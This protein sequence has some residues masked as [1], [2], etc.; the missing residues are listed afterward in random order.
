MNIASNNTS[1]TTK[2]FG[3]GHNN[4]NTANSE[5][6]E[7]STVTQVT[8]LPL[9][10][11]SSIPGRPDI[12]VFKAPSIYPVKGYDFSMLDGEIDWKKLNSAA[13]PHFIYTRAVG[14]K[15]P[16]KTFDDRWSNAK[17]LGI[18]HG[19]YLKFDFCLS[20]DKQFKRLSKIV[21]LEPEALPLAIQIVNP[22]G[23]NGRQLACL[24]S[25][26]IEE[27]KS[28]ILKLASDIRKHYGKTPL[29]HGNRYNLSTFLDERSNEFM[30]WVD[31]Y[32]SLDIQFRGRNP[33]TLW[34]YSLTLNVSG[35]GHKI[36]GDLFFGT[37]EQYELFKKGESNVA[38]E[39]VK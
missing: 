29:L 39:A 9:G 38:L 23:E 18:D 24:N 19:A 20:S 15:G 26:G 7:A 10:P 5:Q 25:M 35:V 17:A 30:I 28:A 21:P 1:D 11:I 4:S 13:R 22:N 36:M 37:E 33:W 8:T 32:K 27:A 6:P 14:W 16:D 12:K 2:S 34:Q 3:I 31:A